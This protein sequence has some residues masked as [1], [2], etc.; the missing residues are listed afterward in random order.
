MGVL[1]T[2]HYIFVND[3]VVGLTDVRVSHVFELGQPLELI[4]R[5]E[6]VVLLPGQH[7]LLAET[8]EVR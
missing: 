5:D 3:V 7:L 1:A 8:E 6:V 4:R 2:A